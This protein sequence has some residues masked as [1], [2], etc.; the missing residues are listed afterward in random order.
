[1]MLHIGGLS[2]AGAHLANNGPYGGGWWKYGGQELLIS[3]GLFE[4]V[5]EKILDGYY[6]TKQIRVFELN[7]EG[8]HSH[9][10]VSPTV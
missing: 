4:C 3:I 7:M 1:M 10:D 5:Q 6:S 8:S 2:G 9:R